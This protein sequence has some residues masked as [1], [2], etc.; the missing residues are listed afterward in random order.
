MIVQYQREII[1]LCTLLDSVVDRRNLFPNKSEFIFI[2]IDVTG[3]A[4]SSLFIELYG[5]SVNCNSGILF[6]LIFRSYMPACREVQV[7]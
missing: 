6:C 5:S 4:I 3:I 7:L 1:K 2:F